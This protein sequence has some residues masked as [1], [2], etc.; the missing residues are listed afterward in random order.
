MRNLFLT[1]F[2]F[3]FK[4]HT[5]IY[6]LIRKL[7]KYVCVTALSCFRKKRKP[8]DDFS[9]SNYAPYILLPNILRIACP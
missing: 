5:F 3:V 1:I 2:I 7:K 8:K 6:V 9:H 4:K